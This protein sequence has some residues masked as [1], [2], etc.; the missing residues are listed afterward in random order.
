LPLVEGKVE[1]GG[2]PIGW[3]IPEG[4]KLAEVNSSSTDCHSDG[5]SH[6]VNST[7]YECKENL[8]KLPLKWE[9]SVAELLKMLL[10]EGNVEHD[11]LPIVWAIPDQTSK[12][13]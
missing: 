8:A 12:N 2:L 6:W 4:E 10:V 7:D 9:L 5:H 11:G 13:S 3:A 1:H